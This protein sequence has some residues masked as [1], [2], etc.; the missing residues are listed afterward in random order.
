M[1]SPSPEEFPDLSFLADIPLESASNNFWRAYGMYIDAAGIVKDAL[2]CDKMNK[3]VAYLADE[4][5]NEYTQAY[6]DLLDALIGEDDHQST[7]ITDLLLQD[8]ATFVIREQI[9]RE[10]YFKNLDAEDI[11]N[12]DELCN[13]LIAQIRSGITVDTSL[14][15]LKANLLETFH[16]IILD[17]Y[18][19]L[20]GE[21]YLESIMLSNDNDADAIREIDDIE[22]K[23]S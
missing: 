11:P 14:G 8:I 10:S 19:H 7:Y 18:T 12:E 17:H 13:D 21:A 16:D 3:T 22:D 4:A 2:I 9:D 1:S 23:D 15:E 20:V 5:I 6:S